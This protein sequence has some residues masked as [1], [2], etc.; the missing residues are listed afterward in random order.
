MEDGQLGDASRAC[1][2][3]S[4]QQSHRVRERIPIETYRSPTTS[5]GSTPSPARQP[6]EETSYLCS[7]VLCVEKKPAP[8]A[9]ANQHAANGTAGTELGKKELVLLTREQKR[10]TLKPRVG[11]QGR[12][13]Y[14]R[15]PPGPPEKK[16][17]SPPIPSSDSGVPG[18][19]RHTTRPARVPGTKRGS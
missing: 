10:P 6:S 15:S 1:K 8:N 11:K 2:T 14:Y 12:P 16:I 3:E 17:W 5:P 9:Q 18:M 19:A 4:Q 13:T 7:L